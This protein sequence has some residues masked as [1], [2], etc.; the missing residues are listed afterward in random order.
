[1]KYLER[2]YKENNTLKYLY[3]V[4]VVIFISIFGIREYFNYKTLKDRDTTQFSIDKSTGVVVKMKRDEYTYEDRKKEYQNHVRMYL[5]NFFGFDQYNFIENM[6]FCKNLMDPKDFEE[7]INIYRTN[8]IYEKIQ[9]EDLILN[10]S[11]RKIEISYKDNV[12]LGFFQILQTS[13]N[14]KITNVNKRIIEGSF[15]IRDLISRTDK[16]IHACSIYDYTVTRIEKTKN[17]D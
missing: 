11:I 6:E 3:F 15:K 9:A 13:R 5:K 17:Y 2:K 4:S 14:P 16:N 8:K 7:E 10:A 12:V 1:M